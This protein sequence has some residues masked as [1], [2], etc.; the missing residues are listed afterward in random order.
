MDTK[1]Q[2][3]AYC[4]KF[5]TA[6]IGNSLELLVKEAEDNAVGFMEFT[7]H[8]LQAE[9]EHRHHNEVIRRRKSARLPRNSDLDR[10]DH[11]FD[12]GVPKN[13]LNQL[14]ELNW[15]DQGYNIMLMGPSGTGKTFLAAGL[16][17]DAI[18]K[19]YKAY[20]RTMEELVNLLKMKDMIR[21]AN[22]DYKRLSKADLIV[23]DDI[24]L[25][26][27]EKNQAVALFNFIN[28][29]YEKTSFIITTNKMATDWA[30][31]LDDEVLATALLDRLLYRCEVI[32]LSG[33]SY[34]M[35]NRKTFFEQEK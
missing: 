16:C 22:A 28:Q 35:E 26:P 27:V 34:R 2:I 13:R 15:L 23:I 1:E 14:R 19:G 11:S 24:M 18:D 10:Y 7:L 20:F 4:R 12:N 5:K 17:A 33:K 6:G 21:T 30:K 29:L 8:L 31:M 25:F 3:T 32:N 9:A